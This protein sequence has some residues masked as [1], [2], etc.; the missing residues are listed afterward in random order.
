VDAKI[1]K[2]FLHKLEHPDEEEDEEE[3]KESSIPI[4]GVNEQETRRTRRKPLT[5]TEALER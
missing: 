4:A 1:A 2:T 5:R 3:Y